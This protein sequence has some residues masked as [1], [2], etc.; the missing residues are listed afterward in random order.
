MPVNRYRRSGG[1]IA[2]MMKVLA[3]LVLL[4][5]LAGADGLWPAQKTSVKAP[6]PADWRSLPKTGQKLADA[7][8]GK[9]VWVSADGHHRATLTST[10]GGLDVECYKV[11]LDG[12]HLADQ[13]LEVTFSPDSRFLFVST[14]PHPLVVDLKTGQKHQLAIDSGLENL[15]VWVHTWSADGATLTLHQQQRFDDSSHPEEWTVHLR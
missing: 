14:G 11:D 12:Q 15:P 8:P 6:L 2:M 1:V 4:V 7:T 3:V 5:A 10:P 13:A 9:S